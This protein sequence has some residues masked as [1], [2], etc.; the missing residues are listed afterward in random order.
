MCGVAGIVSY[1]QHAPDIDQRELLRIRDQMV[2]RG[3][4]DA[5]LWISDN[6]RTGLAHRRLAIIDPG[7][8]GH[9]PMH[10]DHLSITFNGEIYN[11][12]ALRLSLEKQ[13]HQFHTQS[14]TE[15]LLALY[16]SRGIDM[17]HDL[18]GMFAMAIWD[19]RASKLILAR[20]PYGIKPLYYC[21]D[22]KQLKFA[23][24]VKALL[25]GGKVSREIDPASEIG[26]LMLGSVPEP[27]TYYSAISVLPAGSTMEIDGSGPKE[28]RQYGSVTQTW[29]RALAGEVKDDGLSIAE[30]F[31]HSVA[32][33]L[34]SDVPVGVF[35]S[36]GIDSGA[37]SGLMAEQVD[38]VDSI[39]LG[40]EEFVG[41]END[42]TMLATEVAKHY[43]TAHNT[44]HVS[45]SEFN[46]DFEKILMAMDQPT[47]DGLNTW[48]I[49]KA[50]AEKGIK[51]MLSG[52]GGDELLGSYRSFHRIPKWNRYLKWAK[53][54][55]LLGSMTT[56]LGKFMPYN[57]PHPKFWGLCK[58]GGNLP[59]SYFLDRGLFMPWELPAFM[60]HDRLDHGLKQLG[61]FDHIDSLTPNRELKTT[62]SHEN[63]YHAAISSLESS[64]F[65]RN[66]LLRDTD[67]TSMAHSVE[68]RTPLADFYLLNSIA[69]KL[70]KLEQ[71][72]SKNCLASAP[73]KPLPD[74]IVNRQKTGFIVPL[75]KWIKSMPK[76]DYWKSVPMLSNSRCH[77][78]RRY[79]Y[80]LF[81]LNRELRNL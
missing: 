46:Q 45:E 58:Y 34:V 60:E 42:E 67:W 1:D 7:P 24:E 16:Q 28:I 53:Y 3:P 32:R 65:M 68:V 66:Q 81:A 23:S 71:L 41:T 52:L 51:V 21:D 15:V 76:L 73:Q 50:A 8:T 49:S 48:F 72:S 78:S 6:H 13:G 57:R 17:M 14:D 70:L 20:D 33:H 12:R 5:G 77:W 43:G 36:A 29:S 69:P 64:L 61:I 11:F 56:G 44:R 55:P 79:V 39:T 35:L 9:Q 31:K 4:D 47:I 18:V 26:F 80:A 74:H 2:H 19:A 59:S 63:Y 22:G 54:F 37:I 10:R 25:A 62:V 27:R 38:K 75:E 30:N 40:F